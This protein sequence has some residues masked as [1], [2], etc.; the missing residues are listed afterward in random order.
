[1]SA[2]YGDYEYTEDDHIT[3]DKYGVA[4]MYLYPVSKRTT[5]YAGAGWSQFNIKSD[6]FEG[7]EDQAGRQKGVDVA[8]GLTH[9]F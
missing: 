8:F 7:L 6:G 9:R 2:F 3:A 5:V 4:A 1:M